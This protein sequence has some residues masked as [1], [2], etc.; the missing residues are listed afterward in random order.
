MSQS[1]K[2]WID[3]V[4]GLVIAVATNAAPIIT[5]ISGILAMIWYWIRI[6]EY[7]KGKNNVNQRN[8]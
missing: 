1:V 2:H 4:L 5:A 7:L 6:Y 3:I 8:D